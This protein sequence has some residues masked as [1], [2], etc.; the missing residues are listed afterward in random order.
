ML[1]NNI[2]DLRKQKGYSQETLAQELNVVRQTVSKW[3]KGYSVPDAIML[4]KLA[5]V[6]D[7]PVGELLGPEPKAEDQRS[8]IDRITAQLAVLN[9]QM[10][11][12]LARKKKNRKIAL[13][14][15]SVFFSIAL[16][17]VLISLFPLQSREYEISPDDGGIILSYL[18]EDLDEAVSKAIVESNGTGSSGEFTAESHLVYGTDGKADKN[19]VYLFENYSCFGFKDGFFTDIG[20]GST[21]AVLTF[22]K[23]ENGYE[24]V[25]RE[26]ADDGG[27]YSPSVKRL[28]PSRIAK[29]ILS[30]LPEAEKEKMWLEQTNDAREYLK[31]IGRDDAVICAYGEIKTNYFSDYGVSDEV[32]NKIL[33]MALEYD[34]TIGN[35]ERIEGGTR[36]V[37]QTGYD[38]KDDC[39]TFTKFEFE[40]NRIVEFIAVNAKTGEVEKGAPPPEK[41]V[42]YNGTLA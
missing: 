20:G 3:E 5:E 1:A 38:L 28:F 29:K 4:E 14:V 41:V 27:N 39:I 34:Y 7:V 35:H 15:L 26:T 19:K 23:A 31:S 10:A 8:E 18:D 24:L 33:D 9:D 6:F 12:E 30:G 42:Y 13:I 17:A 21:P 40:T 36:F 32:T 2:K 16:I 11:R 25:S 37:Y 22:K